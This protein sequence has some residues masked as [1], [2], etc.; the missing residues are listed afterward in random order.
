MNTAVVTGKVRLSYVS[1][2]EPRESQNGGDAKYSATILL[3]KGD[4]DTMNR[5]QT[6]IN[7]A[8]QEGINK[9]WGGQQ[10][11]KIDIPLRDGDGVRPNGE[12]FGDECKGCWV[13][14]ASSRTRPGVVD[15]RVQPILDST[16][17][18]SGMYAHVDINL[19]PYNSNGKKGIGFGLNN[20]QK[21][22]DGEPF[23]SRRSA[24]AAFTAVAAPPQG[25]PTPFSAPS[26]AQSPAYDQLL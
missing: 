20:V 8:A 18:Y 9:K 12:A 1:L 11:A 19:Y 6:A 26:Y 25:A 22:A 4:T 21:V 7:A 13:F 10:P 15:Q 24:Q 16:Q 5:I 17:V 3:P 23:T 14:T 2:F